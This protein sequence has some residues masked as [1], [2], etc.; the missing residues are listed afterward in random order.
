MIKSII[1]NI[2]YCFSSKQI[3]DENAQAISPF[4]IILA[5][6][7][8]GL[9]LSAVYAITWKIFGDI[10]FTDRSRL[11][12]IP[13]AMI[14]LIMCILGYRQLIGVMLITNRL[15]GDGES[16]ENP[17]LKLA[18]I[19]AVIVIILLKYSALLAMPNPT[20]WLPADW[21]R[22]FA[23]A[24]PKVNFR[25]L[26]LLALWGKTAILIAG[27][28]GPSSIK[29]ELPEKILRKKISIKSLIANL[30]LTFILTTIYFSNLNSRTIGLIISFVIFILV[31]LTS[32]FLA[33]KNDGHDKYSIFACAELAEILLL[34][35]YLAIAKF[36]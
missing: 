30:M 26:I 19:L 2:K 4:K 16:E 5:G 28:T 15:T 27:A 24:Y 10:Y 14:I 1:T 18:G 23:F 20:P 11:R 25:V 3:D 33:W 29:I 9:I 36:L 34:L 22:Y 21:R 6:L 31:Y 35:S 7:L 17:N 32:I 8:Y 13:S 12:I